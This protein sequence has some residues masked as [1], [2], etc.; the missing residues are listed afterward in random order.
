EKIGELI[1]DGNI[2]VWRYFNPNKLDIYSW[3]SYR[4]GARAN[5]VGW[6]IDYFIVNKEFI[7]E[8][9]NIEYLTD[10]MGSDHCP[11]MLNLK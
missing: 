4:A 5:N 1:N 8:I 6:R 2:D 3:W 10:V 9:E 7:N 11:V